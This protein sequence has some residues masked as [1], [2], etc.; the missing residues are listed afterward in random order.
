MEDFLQDLS[1]CYV[2]SPMARRLAS[3]FMWMAG[4]E[5]DMHLCNA[6]AEEAREELPRG[7]IKVSE[8]W[9]K[10]HNISI[11]HGAM[12]LLHLWNIFGLRWSAIELREILDEAL[13][14]SK[15]IEIVKQR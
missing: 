4:D 13:E 6:M 7:W 2:T 14:K 8:E 12:A 1:K 3:Q 5:H 15:K 10:D 9:C 11:L